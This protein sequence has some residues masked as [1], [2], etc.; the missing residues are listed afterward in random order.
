MWRKNINSS[1]TQI[2]LVKKY[3]KK[4]IHTII[5]LLLIGV[6][7]FKRVSGC[8]CRRSPSFNSADFSVFMRSL[9]SFVFPIVFTFR[10]HRSILR[11]IFDL[12]LS[13][14]RFLVV[15]DSRP[16]YGESSEI[17]SIARVRCAPIMDLQVIGNT[18]VGCEWP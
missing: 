12:Y 5:T 16:N 10:F 3:I 18:F 2:T 7:Y 1:F 11:F 4:I 15:S 9:Q 6:L 14:N 8:I 17:S 13:S